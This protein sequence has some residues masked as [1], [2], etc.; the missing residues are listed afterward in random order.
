[1]PP[2]RGS[3][4]YP[5]PIDPQRIMHAAAGLRQV[6]SRF[7][8]VSGRLDAVARRAAQTWTGEAA[9]TFVNHMDDRALGFRLVLDHVNEAADALDDLAAELGV[10]QRAYTTYA[11]N[12]QM[13]RETSP[14][15]EERILTAIADQRS[16]VRDIEVIGARFRNNVA[17]VVQVLDMYARDSFIAVGERI[18]VPCMESSTGGNLIADAVGATEDT[19]IG[20]DQMQV[21]VLSD[22]SYLLVLPG[23]MDL[24]NLGFALGD[25]INSVRTVPNAGRTA[26]WGGQPNNY[27]EMVKM[28]MR[29]AGIP[30]G[31]EVTIVG[32]SYGNYTAMDLAGDDAFNSADGTGD[33]YNVRIRR[34]V[35]IAADTDW[36][37]KRVPAETDVVVL[38]SRDDSVYQAEAQI[39]PEVDWVIRRDRVLSPLPKVQPVPVIPS[40]EP[41]LTSNPT[42][43]YPTRRPN[44]IEV[45]VNAGKG[46]DS[47]DK[48]SGHHPNR[49]SPIIRTSANTPM[50]RLFDEMG[51]VTVVDRF[52]LRLPDSVPK[53]PPGR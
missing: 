30:S 5:D 15:N 14:P 47:D 13:G 22:G 29:R 21:Q 28:A 39:D 4:A 19:S 41:S 3:V 48:L 12:E 1:M 43:S 27:A 2:V 25:D 17:D 32:H 52:N 26:L 51:D 18:L 23:V 53:V 37:M 20:I 40:L 38:N 31:A 33:G 6:T 10:N 24:S 34:V 42:T 46:F 11:T 8:D 44:Q 16:V 9:I 7:D 36:K 35:G 50:G 45:E 49:Y